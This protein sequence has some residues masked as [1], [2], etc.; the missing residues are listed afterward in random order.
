MKKVTLKD[1]RKVLSFCLKSRSDLP[2]IIFDDSDE[3]LL[4]RDMVKDFHLTIANYSGMIVALNK[5]CNFDVPKELSIV[6]SGNKVKDFMDTYNLYVRYE[7]EM[8]QSIKEQKHSS[9]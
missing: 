4:E 8:N 1:I 2:F 7:K 6:M 3:E 5:S 9:Y